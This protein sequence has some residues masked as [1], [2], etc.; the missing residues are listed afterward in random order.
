MRPSVV[1]R[2]VRMVLAALIVLGCAYLLTRQRESLMAA[3]HQ[4]SPARVLGSAL[5]A[6]A[7]GMCIE[8]TWLALLKGFG[9]SVSNR[10]AAPVFYTTQL[11]KYVPGSVWPVLAQV[12]LGT[13]LGVPR[14]LMLGASILLLTMVTATGTMVGA[15]LLPWSSPDGI[16]RYW[17]LLLL[18]PVLLLM[19]H[20]RVVAWLLHR[21]PRFARI[22]ALETQVSAKSLV[23]A[24][25]WAVLGWTVLGTHLLLLLSAY[26]A[27][28]IRLTAAA[29]GGIGLAW[30]AGLAFIPAPAGAGVREAVLVV[31]LSPLVGT[32]AALATAVASRVLLTIA[33][34][35]LAGGSAA[36]RTFG[37][38]RTAPAERSARGT[39]ESESAP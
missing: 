13:H 38:V 8:R 3:I 1:R 39:E 16:R 24:G 6:I 9:V 4:L 32:H 31:T 15:L 28:D 10:D 33:D 18:L 21:V 22:E 29:I 17:W 30:A 26:E 27:F 35:V 37:Q 11:G 34:V 7:A 23:R 19:L 2:V 20:P 5:V 12:Q 25:L 36:F 14:R